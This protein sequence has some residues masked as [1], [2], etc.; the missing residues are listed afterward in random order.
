MDCNVV[1]SVLHDS[2]PGGLPSK[3]VQTVVPT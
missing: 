2:G 3:F 1:L